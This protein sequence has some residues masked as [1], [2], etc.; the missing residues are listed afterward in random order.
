MRQIELIVVHCT[1]SPP[2]MDI[3]VEEIRKWH[4]EGNGW[5]DIGYHYVIRRD[6]EVEVGRPLKR[7][8]AH[9]KGY[10]SNSI[11]IAW[12]GGMASGSD[13]PE[14]NRTAAQNEA[15]VSL[16]KELQQ[17]FPGAALLGHRDLKGVKKD[18]PC[19][20]VREWFVKECNTEKKEAE[21]PSRSAK[22]V[23]P[24]MIFK[25]LLSITWKLWK[26]HRSTRQR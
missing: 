8:G 22:T 5:S 11:A 12:V 21:E 14:D 6:G 13:K 19:F 20:D 24:S 15:M 1:Y 17:E 25:Y 23:R 2:R 26:Y 16:I 3:G 9:A 4:V 10:N 7:P 18:C